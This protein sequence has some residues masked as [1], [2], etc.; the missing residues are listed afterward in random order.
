MTFTVIRLHHLLERLAAN[1]LTA[2]RQ[3]Q[4][5]AITRAMARIDQVLQRNPSQ[6]GESRPG[7]A[8]VLVETPLTV[9]FEIH[10]DERIVIITR[11]R[12]APRRRP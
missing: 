11:A 1:Y 7:T 8:R 4:G 2:R 12:Y 5:A 10:E 9:D 3:G 6:Q